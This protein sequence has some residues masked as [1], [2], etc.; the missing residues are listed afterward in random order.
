MDTYIRA[1]RY[2]K[3]PKL[4]WIPGGE[5][6]GVVEQ[7]GASVE[8]PKKGDRVFLLPSSAGGVTGTYGQ[9]TVTKAVNALPLVDSLSFQQ[10]C[11]V[12]GAYRTA[13]RA[14]VIRARAKKGDVVMVHGASGGVGSATCQLAVAM[15]CKCIGTAGT[16]AGMNI[17]KEMGCSPLNHRT[18]NYLDAIPELTDGKGVNVIVEMLANVNLDKDLKILARGGV[19]AVVGNRGTI[20]V[21]PR[22]LMLKESSVV[23]VLGLGTEEEQKAC[24]ETLLAGTKD[25][26]LKPR[27]GITYDLKGASEAHV[28]VIEHKQGTKGKLVLLPFPEDSKKDL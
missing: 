24:R 16:E 25:G 20:E 15:G 18:E 19:V 22:D 1:G 9:Y 26:S 2:G 21:N 14:L 11:A 13:Y 6:A 17:V 12:G 7:V 8:S 3:L 28:E 27:V 5:G 4:P 23:G 10:G